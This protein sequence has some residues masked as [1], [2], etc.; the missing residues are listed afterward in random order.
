M[1]SS[2]SQAIAPHRAPRTDLV[3][4]FEPE[5]DEV[6]NFIAIQSGKEKEK[7]AVAA[8]LRW[9]LLENSARQPNHPLGFGLRSANQLVGCILCS[10]Q[11]F[12]LR[13]TTI[14]LM[15]SS[16]FYVDQKYRSSGGRIFL[17]YCRLGNQHPLFGTSA[18]AEAAAL[19]KAAGANP[20]PYS[21][22]ELF[23]ILCWPPVA[24]EFAHRRRSN[25]LLLGLAGSRLASVGGLLR[26]LKM[27]RRDVS[28]LR[29]LHSAEQVDELLSAVPRYCPT[30]T[31]ARDLPYLRWRYFSGRDQTVAAFAFRT[32]TPGDE[33]LV[34]VNQRARGYRGQINTLNVL[35]VYPE[36][37]SEE[38]LRIVGALIARYRN[39]VDAVVL[40]SQNPDRRRAF[41]ARGF[42][43]RA[44]D[45]PNG[46]FLDPSK[47]L[48]TRDWYPVPADGDGLI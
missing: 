33:I 14:L 34:T 3:P 37:P 4:I 10:P 11:M 46:W 22:E 40:R 30:L 2:I 21:D 9:F 6:A 23:G 17:Q 26:P 28:G 16:L 42:Q 8:H 20:I 35:D 25:R 18:N 1:S 27:D 44:L 36:V 19:W 47:L 48:P 32:R 38:W 45:A 12:R 15:G 13:E 24:E 7:D 5:V 39:T 43:P 31:A 41:C 29:L